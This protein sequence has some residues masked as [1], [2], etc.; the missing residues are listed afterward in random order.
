MKYLKP[1]NSVLGKVLWNIWL[2][3]VPTI[4]YCS[5]IKKLTCFFFYFL[6]R[7]LFCHITLLGRLKASNNNILSYERCVSGIRKSLNKPKT[8]VEGLA[9]TLDLQEKCSGKLVEMK[10]KY[11]YIYFVWK[12]FANNLL[13]C[14]LNWVYNRA[15]YREPGIWSVIYSLNLI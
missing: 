2:R 11:L 12:T 7:I 5:A 14:N 9:N 10:I 4:I 15:I 6:C 8:R 1:E 3:H 13:L